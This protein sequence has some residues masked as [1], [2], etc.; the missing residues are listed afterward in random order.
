M[1]Y[2]LVQQCEILTPSQVGSVQVVGVFHGRFHEAA[3]G[4][5]K[6]GGYG[7]HADRGPHG[8]VRSNQFLEAVEYSGNKAI[9]PVDLDVG[10]RSTG[11]RGKG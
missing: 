5:S 4:E 2:Q 7:Q 9:R 3:D 1:V 10:E 11:S 6:V 8:V